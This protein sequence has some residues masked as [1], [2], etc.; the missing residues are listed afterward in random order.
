MEP[1]PEGAVRNRLSSP[2]VWPARKALALIH[3]PIGLVVIFAPI[4]LAVAILLLVEVTVVRP[5]LLETR[6]HDGASEKVKRD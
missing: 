2:I 1:L 3:I 5:S 4:C 6:A